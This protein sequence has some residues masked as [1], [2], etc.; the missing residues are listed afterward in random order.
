MVW[1]T[2]SNISPP[3]GSIGCFTRSSLLVHSR[4]FPGNLAR[5][6]RDIPSARV[7]CTA[8]MCLASWLQ[9]VF[10]SWRPSIFMSKHALLSLAPL[11]RLTHGTAAALSPR[12]NVTSTTDSGVSPANSS[13]TH[14]VTTILNSSRKLIVVEHVSRRSAFRF[15]SCVSPRGRSYL[16]CLFLD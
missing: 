12:I 3:P 7:F 16:Q 10:I 6:Q 1:S 13:I 4:I 15:S 14:A 11:Q 8:G 2:R 5:G 9:P